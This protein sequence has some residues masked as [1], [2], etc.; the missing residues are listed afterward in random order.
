MGRGLLLFIALLI[1]VLGFGAWVWLSQ[2][3]TVRQIG[4]LAD[5]VELEAEVGVDL[6]LQGI[7]LTQAEAGRTQWRLTAERASYAQDEGLVRVEKPKVA[8]YLSNGEVFNV[9]AAQGEVRQDE[10]KARLWPDVSGEYDDKTIT[11]QQL[12]WSGG[13][14]LL[15]LSGDVRMIAP[16]AEFHAPSLQFKLDTNILSAE[17]GVRITIMNSGSIAEGVNLP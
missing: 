13:E 6:S 9:S 15:A 14:Q 5:N 7:E 11:A 12:D 4:E 3:E 8:Y 17:D 2:D 16:Q 10:Q 1:G